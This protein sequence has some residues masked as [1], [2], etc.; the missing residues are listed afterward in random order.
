MKNDFLVVEID[1]KGAE[2]KSIYH[3]QFDLNYLWNGD[4]DYWNRSAPV[5]FPIV[6]KLKNN[7]YSYKDNSY[8]L[9]QHGF[10]RDATFTVEKAN[11]TEAVFLLSSTIETKKV[12]P[13]DFDLHIIYTLSNASLN[14]A[15]RVLH[16]GTGKMFFSIG[17][18]PGF[19]C[20]LEQG[21]AFEDYRLTFERKETTKRLLVGTDGI[22]RKTE[23]V[24][25]DNTNVIP[26]T[27][28]LFG[29]KD[30]IIFKSLKSDSITLTSAK[31]SHGLRFNFRGFPYMG[32][33]TKPGPFLCIEP[34]YGIAD[35]EDANGKLENK[36][37]IIELNT[38]ET[39]HASY[40]MEFF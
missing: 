36:E 38:Q 40:S 17:A 9:T 12:Y 11:E 6:G 18:H 30:A 1:T 39:F 27:Y 33:W 23:Q 34:W 14:V 21:L 25:A 29:A 35:F 26:L 10:A 7:T 15:Y 28:D 8:H 37:G 5:L 2:I 24:F 32:I 3:R 20:P 22:S 13:F 16:K 4:A 31:S 19:N